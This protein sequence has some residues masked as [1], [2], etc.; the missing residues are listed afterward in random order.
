MLS[1]FLL[2]VISTMDSSVSGLGAYRFYP[3][4]L[5]VNVTTGD[6]VYMLNGLR[7]KTIVDLEKLMSAAFWRFYL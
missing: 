4:V 3:R 2:M 5:S 7:V 1:M 6:V